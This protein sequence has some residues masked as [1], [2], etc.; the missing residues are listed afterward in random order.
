MRAT[1]LKPTNSQCGSGESSGHVG[2]DAGT[3]TLLLIRF[4]LIY[5]LPIPACV[6]LNFDAWITFF[7]EFSAFL[8]KGAHARF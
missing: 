4:H 8:C 1:N 6:V 5:A 2:V 7:Q 3:S